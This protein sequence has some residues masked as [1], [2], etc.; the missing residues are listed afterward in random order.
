MK[1]VKVIEYYT[2]KLDGNK[3]VIELNNCIGIDRVFVD[4]SFNSMQCDSSRKFVDKIHNLQEAL[5]AVGYTSFQVYNRL[6]EAIALN[7]GEL[8]MVKTVEVKDL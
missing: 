8:D 4:Q 2:F 7:G 1:T 3:Y 5:Y 6:K